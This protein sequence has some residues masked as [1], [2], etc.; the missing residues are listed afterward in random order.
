M[1]SSRT[2]SKAKSAPSEP[3]SRQQQREATRRRILDAA[4]SNFAR[5]GYD[6][7]NFREITALCGAE[8]PLILYHYQSKEQ[9]WKQAVQEVEQRF[10]SAFEA[11]YQPDGGG[12]D[13]DK[14]RYA[15]HSFIDTLCAVPEYGQILLREGSSSGPRMEWLARHFV[16]RRALALELD[17]PSIAARMQKTVLRDILGSTLVAFVTLGPVMERSLAG[18]TRQKSAGVHPL[19]SARKR[20]LVDYMLKLVFD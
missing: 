15:M 2:P 4:I 11:R 1:A 3:G 16:P 5:L 10:N 18:V 20:E 8:R 17:D 9:L 19:T 6:G 12:S 7:T 13:R 14:V